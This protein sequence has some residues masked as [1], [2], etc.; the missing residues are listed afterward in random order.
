M[1][2]LQPWMLLAL[3]LVA[4]PVIIHLINQRRYQTM[5]WAAMMFLL[6][7]ARMARGYARIRQ[8]LILAFRTAV[9]AALVV[10]VSRP[11]A[12]GWLGLA[13]GQRPDTTLI[14]LDRSPS[15]Q[16]REF[17]SERSKLT[18][19]TDQLVQTLT[20][21]GS[22]RWAVVDSARQ[23]PLAI[24]SIAS[25]GD[26]TAAT[27]AG[28]SADLPA[29]L[30]SA[31]D[32]IRDNRS[33][34]TDI[35]I[36]SDLRANDWKPDSSRWQTLRDDFQSFPQS[37]RF[38][39]LAFPQTASGNVAIQVTEARRVET[40]EGAELWLS[41]VLTRDGA[42]DSR[43]TSPVAIEIE[44]AR[45]VV[46]VEWVGPKTELKDHRIPLPRDHR[47]G[48]GVV[49]IPADAN[50]ADNRYY[51]VFGEPTPRHTVIVAEH[52]GVADL[53]QVAATVAPDAQT[54]ATAEVVSLAQLPAVEWESVSLLLWQG[55]LPSVESPSQAEAAEQIE[56]FI[57]R[58]GQAIF[59]PSPE[60][61]MGSFL[62]VSW[63]EWTD[64]AG[65]EKV[66]TWRGDQDLLVNTASGAALPVGQ[67]ELRQRMSLEGEFT[68]LATLG[69]GE[70]LVGRVVSGTGAAYFFGTTPAGE[71]SSLAADGVVF[72]VMVQRALAAG[73]AALGNTH[74]WD[75]GR[76]I[77]RPVEPSRDR[78][79]DTAESEWVEGQAASTD[80]WRKLAGESSALSS[81]YLYQP[82]V[83]ADGERLLAVNRPAEEDEPSTVAP[84]RLAELFRD[85]D[86]T[87]VDTEI[88]RGGG[89][90]QE[91]WRPVVMAMIVA[92]MFEAGL[93]MPRR[94]RDGV[95]AP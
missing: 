45:S 15:M 29:M 84:E 77:R 34:R 3:P 68:P 47:R 39:L 28:N 19:A 56:R 23:E 43:L 64:E 4:L 18:A 35:W 50:L 91:V 30:E 81:E 7:A 11:L 88:G 59:F 92:M 60:A 95:P 80:T 9:I 94:G 21:L 8:W 52:A 37:V 13:G 61:A 17:G 44:S 72:Y 27:E 26:L 2:F 16:Q 54:Q 48:W 6:A 65:E 75:A 71:H 12:S 89:L 63:G 40:A 31:R 67:I 22:N 14:L 24:E 90:V 87:R 38:H 20:T 53:L 55:R 82:G 85:L 10:A 41:L 74:Q 25:L 1:M 57:E 86:F 62:G 42:A 79:E 66:A 58:G 73:A 33:G 70:P 69:G 51:F 93:S 83:Y 46:Q 32:F 49:S 76:T 78:G 36:A 5:P